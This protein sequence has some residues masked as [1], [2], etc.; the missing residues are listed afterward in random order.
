MSPMTKKPESR[1]KLNSA[2]EEGEKV[3]PIIN[4]K[5]KLSLHDQTTNQPQ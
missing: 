1:N 2:G 3:K 5:T 4:I